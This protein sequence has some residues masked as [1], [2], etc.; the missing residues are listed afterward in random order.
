MRE[1]SSRSQAGGIR[2]LAGLLLVNA[3]TAVGRARADDVAALPLDVDPRG[4]GA[5]ARGY[6]DASGQAVIEVHPA[7]GR[8]HAQ[9]VGDG[10][11]GGEGEHG[12]DAVLLGL[13]IRAVRDVEI[14]DE[15]A[16]VVAGLDA[17]AAAWALE[18]VVVLAPA[19][20]RMLADVLAPG[21]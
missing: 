5:P 6:V 13:A 21:A 18:V 1:T 19:N 11:S 4:Q 10:P 7:R 2:Q 17:V 20:E 16:V 8:E 9:R 15:D 3:P 12:T 14:N